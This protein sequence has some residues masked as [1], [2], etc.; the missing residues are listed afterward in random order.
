MSEDAFRSPCPIAR[1]LDVLGDRWT[2]LVVR[3]LLLR[4][5]RTYSEMRAGPER[6]PTNLL[7]DRLKRLEAWGLV[8]RERYSDRP[9]RF[10]Y[11]LTAKGEALRPV[12]A[13]L[14]EWGRA[15]LAAPPPAADDA[16]R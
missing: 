11:A 4:G 6:I 16:G 12:L 13:A 2:L 1:A 5:K 9:P 15:E 10:A 8:T 14:A 7:A 3:D